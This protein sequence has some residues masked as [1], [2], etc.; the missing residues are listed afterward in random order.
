M[1]G[2]QDRP[3]IVCPIPAGMIPI[4][5]RAPDT[6]IRHSEAEEA[7]EAHLDEMKYRLRSRAIATAANDVRT[8]M[9]RDFVF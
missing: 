5:I 6:W 9:K 2:V 7:G 3:G 1:T 4:G 8:I